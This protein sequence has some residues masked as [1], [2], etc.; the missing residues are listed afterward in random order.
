MLK[1]KRFLV[2]HRFTVANFHE[3]TFLEGAIF[4]NTRFSEMAHFSILPFLIR[5]NFYVRENKTR[6]FFP[7]RYFQL[8]IQQKYNLSFYDTKFFGLADFSRIKFPFFTD[9]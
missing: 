9:Y 3:A 4:Y 1:K 2:L 5:S 6:L 7:K 8:M